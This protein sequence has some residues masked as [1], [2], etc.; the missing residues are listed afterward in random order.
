M[1][2]LKYQLDPILYQQLLFIINIEYLKLFTAPKCNET[3]KYEKNEK[4][5]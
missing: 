5:P 1:K 3:K 4:T 2:N